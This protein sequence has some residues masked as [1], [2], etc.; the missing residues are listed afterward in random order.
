M[1]RSKALRYFDG[2]EGYNCA[3]AIFKA[4]ETEYGISQK[5]IDGL[6]KKGFGRTEGGRCGALYAVRTLV[7]DPESAGTVERQFSEATGS[8][9]CR[10][11][12]RLKRVTCEGCVDIAARLL[13]NFLAS[14]LCENPPLDSPHGGNC[15]NGTE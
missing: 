11:I 8:H 3:Q 9:T 7:G 10:R 13:Q 1:Y 14:R 6:K 5:Q 12:R 4:F 15:G 2:P